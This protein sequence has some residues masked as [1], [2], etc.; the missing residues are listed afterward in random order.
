MR[1]LTGGRP[2]HAV[3]ARRP[4]RVFLLRSSDIRWEGFRAMLA[5][6]PDMV[7][8]GD[9][10]SV[11][12]AEVRIPA[13]RPNVICASADRDDVPI[14]ALVRRLQD[15]YR[16]SRVLVIG[17]VADHVTLR[18]LVHLGALGYLLWRDV[19]AEVAR[20]SVL[21]ANAGLRVG[22]DLVLD[23]LL[24]PRK[25]RDEIKTTE[26]AVVEGLARGLNEAEIA[27]S[28]ALSVRTV[29]RTIADLKRR[30]NADSLFVLGAWASATG[31]ID[32]EEIGGNPPRD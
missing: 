22:T 3:Q 17:E 24:L 7:I 14:I 12:Q 6:Q 21:A 16:K 4:V 26:K 25:E 1:N 30:V 19:D 5:E 11:L 29:E 23:E 15:I 9:A 10:V 27:S 13:A 28:C 8:V 20:A 31:L 18:E 32:P 2:G